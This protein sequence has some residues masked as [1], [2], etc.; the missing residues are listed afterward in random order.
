MALLPKPAG[1]TARTSFPLRR[2]PLV[3]PTR[4]KPLAVSCRANSEELSSTTAI[5]DL[6]WSFRWIYWQAVDIDHFDWR[7]ID[8]SLCLI[9]SSSSKWRLVKCKGSA[10]GFSFPP[11]PLPPLPL[12]TLTHAFARLSPAKRKWKRLLRRL[13]L[14]TKGINIYLDYKWNSQLTIP[15]L[16]LMHISPV[17]CRTIPLVGT[18]QRKTQDSG[19]PW[20]VMRKLSR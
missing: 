19:S 4:E 9:A 17:S 13:Y 3:F 16:M 7:V 11:H 6:I 15:H 20:Q 5:I 10:A 14:D 12:F 18:G 2:Q 8:Q 1:K